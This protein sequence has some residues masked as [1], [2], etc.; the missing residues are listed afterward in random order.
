[1]KEL[2]LV[3]DPLFPKA[4]ISHHQSLKEFL[5]SQQ[6]TDVNYI[7]ET[8]FDFRNM[9]SDRFKSVGRVNTLI[10]LV[11]NSLTFCI[12]NRKVV[13]N[14][15]IFFPHSD[16]ISTTVFLIARKLKLINVKMIIRMIGIRDYTQFGKLGTI[17]VG[18]LLNM[19]LQSSDTLTA[20]TYALCRKIREIQKK[21]NVVI[22]TPYP[23]FLKIRPEAHVKSENIFLFVGTPRIDKGYL[24]VL[25]LPKLHPN[26]EFRIQLPDNSDLVLLDSANSVSSF[27]NVQFFPP[28]KTDEDIMKEI[29]S[30][31]ALLMPYDRNKFAMRGS[32]VITAAILVGKPIIGHLE[33]SFAEECKGFTKFVSLENFDSFEKISMPELEKHSSDYRD[34]IR[35]NWNKILK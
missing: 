15:T 3:F 25:A 29:S 26:L 34:Y 24:D 23:G 10:Y 19:T 32:G 33:T 9:K 21:S 7:S 14:K 28:L 11:L 16:F 27:K 35:S 12:N 13:D 18:S 22:H 31:R 8:K 20:E 2:I 4:G 30:A 5:E 6:G 17:A 1:M